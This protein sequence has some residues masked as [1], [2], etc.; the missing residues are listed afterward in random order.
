MPEPPI[1]IVP[2]VYTKPGEREVMGLCIMIDDQDDK[3][4]VTSSDNYTTT[5][6]IK[7]GSKWNVQEY[8]DPKTGK[9]KIQIFREGARLNSLEQ[10]FINRTEEAYTHDA[11]AT[12]GEGPQL[13]I[14]Y[15]TPE[16]SHKP[17]IKK[18]KP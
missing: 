6:K 7:N 15:T 18:P 9:R 14:F 11:S 13:K 2:G 10:K 8:T 4:E 1:D 3:W 16:D 5:I 17:P 12:K